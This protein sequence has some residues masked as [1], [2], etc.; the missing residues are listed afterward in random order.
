MIIINSYYLNI[1]NFVFEKSVY[2]QLFLGKNKNEGKGEYYNYS[3][4]KHALIAP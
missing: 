2:F 4:L 3:T 1:L